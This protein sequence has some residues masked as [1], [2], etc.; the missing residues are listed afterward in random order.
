MSDDAVLSCL[1][2]RQTGSTVQ[3]NPCMSF[4]TTRASSSPKHV[5]T[6]GRHR[7]NRKTQEEPEHGTILHD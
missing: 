5:E 4:L 7:T 3:L 2:R 6:E 1:D